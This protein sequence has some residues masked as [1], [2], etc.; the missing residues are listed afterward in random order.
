MFHYVE[1]GGLARTSLADV[2][3]NNGLNLSDVY[4][5]VIEKNPVMRRT[6]A[7]VLRVLGVRHLRVTGDADEAFDAH[8]GYPADIILTDWT[9]DMDTVNL[10][11]RIRTD[12]RSLNPFVPI[13]MVSAFTER[14]QV[15]SAR[16]GGITDFLA[17]P[18]T[19]P[20]LYGRIRAAVQREERFVNSE[21]Y[22]GPDRRR[23]V[24]PHD[25]NERRRTQA[26][27]VTI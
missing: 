23:R 21:Q 18:Y 15:Y 7:Q 9:P 26:R 12:P 17:K 13:I 1:D 10:V 20:N 22:F 11:R 16:D 8:C 4:F 27:H 6:I 25:G 14:R 19:V 5:L 3:A 24:R 2:S